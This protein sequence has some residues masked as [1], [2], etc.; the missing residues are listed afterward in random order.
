M[1]KTKV[2]PLATP[3]PPIAN[4]AQTIVWPL[5]ANGPALQQA[6]PLI[7]PSRYMFEQID[8]APVRVQV[9]SWSGSK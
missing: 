6:G 5:R 4:D 7:T 8:I 2:Y 9:R 1:D 3:S